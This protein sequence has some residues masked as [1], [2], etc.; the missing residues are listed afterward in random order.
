MIRQLKLAG[1]DYTIGWQHG[2]QVSDLRPH[3]LTVMQDR[4]RTMNECGLAT[5]PF[6]EELFETWQAQ[7]KPLMAMLKGIAD[8]MAIEWR[9]FFR[10]SAATYL[11]DRAR[12]TSAGEIRL[13]SRGEQGCTVWAAARDATRSN[14]PMLVKNRD[15]W[16]DHQRLQCLAH[17]RPEE[18]YPYLNLTSA[19]SPGVFSSG[20]NVAGLVVADTHVASLELGLGLPR[21]YLMMDILERHASVGS[22]LDYLRSVKHTGN[23]TLLLL[24]ADG[25]TAV[26]ECGY[27]TTATIHARRDI[28]VST[29]HYVSPE[30]RQQWV[31]RKAEERLADNSLGRYARVQESLQRSAGQIDL[32]WA[33]E[34]MRSHNGQRDSLCR[35]IEIDPKSI[36]ISSAIYLPAEKRLYLSNGQPC[37]V[38]Y[39]AIKGEW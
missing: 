16:P 14:A 13:D 10:Y 20:M 22:A 26:M 18:G 24:D 21:F 1:D 27:S 12:Q 5:Q 30:L 36:T 6:E 4:L 39:E 25:E 3:L 31:P 32:A 35:H 11:M 8:A 28:A 19:G 2:Q 34:L 23:G 38:E 9:T 37:Q 15:Y 17:T 7:A 29:N 33:M